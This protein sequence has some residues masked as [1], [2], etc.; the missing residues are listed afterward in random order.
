MKRRA[1]RDF[2]KEF[3]EEA[4]RLAQSGSRPLT[5]VARSLDVDQGVLR[6]WIKAQETEGVDAFRGHGKRTAA[7][8][9][10]WRLRLKVRSLEQELDFLKKVS[11]YFAKD[12]K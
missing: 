9:E 8:E 1:R 6:R 11:R 3:K 10:N 7:E 4:V 2:T 5:E 12:P